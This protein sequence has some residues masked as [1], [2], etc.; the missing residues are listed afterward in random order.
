M[1]SQTTW[2]GRVTHVE[3]RAEPG[4][5]TEPLGIAGIGEAKCRDDDVYNS[6]TGY[7]IAAGRAFR[8]FGRQ[9]EERGHQEVVTRIQLRRA[10]HALA[11]APWGLQ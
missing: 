2:S 11:G 6:N 7:L 3:V 1:F 5:K 10:L 8:D 9:V 4:S